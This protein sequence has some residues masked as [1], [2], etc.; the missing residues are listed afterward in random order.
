MGVSEGGR[1]DSLLSSP[2]G[3]NP[4]NKTAA[5][6]SAARQ[7]EVNPTAV[8]LLDFNLGNYQGARCRTSCRQYPHEVTVMT[9]LSK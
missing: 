8:K 1:K 3:R 7:K 9:L 4:S 6:L 2:E 5:H